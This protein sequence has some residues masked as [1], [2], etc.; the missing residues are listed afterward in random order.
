MAEKKEYVGVISE[1]NRTRVISVEKGSNTHKLAEQAEGDGYFRGWKLANPSQVKKAA[2]EKK[3]A[4]SAEGK[5]GSE[6]T[7]STEPTAN[8]NTGGESAGEGE[9]GKGQAQE[10][11]PAPQGKP[12]RQGSKQTKKEAK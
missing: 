4:R 2:E 10:Q 9:E 8:E 12:K 3:N 7:K 5:E 11:T 1:R 6:P